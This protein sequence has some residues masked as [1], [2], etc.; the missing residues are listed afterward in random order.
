MGKVSSTRQTSRADWLAEALRVLEK[1]GVAAVRIDRLARNL[2]T[3]RSGFYWHFADR[4]ELLRAILE[5]WSGAY[6]GIVTGDSEIVALP[7]HARL[8]RI[9][10]MIAAHGLSRYEIAM[11][12]WAAHDR[13]VERAV[14]RVYGERCD[15]VR[16]AFQELGFRGIDLDIRARLFLAYH[17]WERAMFEDGS[18]EEQARRVAA[19]LDLLTGSG[20]GP[21]E[22]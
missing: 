7:P 20:D 2:G 13:D 5:Y 18:P 12:A 16:R 11:R 9:A 15:F 19:E 6:T 8:A 17:T 4:A 21:G 10:D 22:S 14:R 3:S 1:G